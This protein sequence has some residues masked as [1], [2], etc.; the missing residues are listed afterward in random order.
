M[1]PLLATLILCLAANAQDDDPQWRRNLG[2]ILSRPAEE[3][4]AVALQ[5]FEQETR[6]AVPYFATF[7]PHDYEAN[8]ALVRNMAIYLARIN[9]MSG[10]NPQ[11]RSAL[12]RANLALLDLRYAY[13]L[14]PASEPVRRAESRPASPRDPPFSLA[15]PSIKGVPEADRVT[16]RD[17][18]SSYESAAVK[19]LTAWQITEE[20]SQNLQARGMSINTLT[21]ASIARVQMFMETAA[22]AMRDRDWD[23]A[24]T[25][26]ERAAYES[27][28]VLKAAGR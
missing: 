2:G 6:L 4:D 9:A 24:R 26:I 12:R 20:L 7:T 23:D 14:A 28:K 11:L 1:R 15:A 19:A 5:R 27:D 13:P 18:Q 21:A 8:R 10:K 17:L 25:N 22:G 16:A 3:A